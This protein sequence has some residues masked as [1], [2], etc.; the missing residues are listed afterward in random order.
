[1]LWVGPVLVTALHPPAAGDGSPAWRGNDGSLVLRLDWGPTSVVLTGDAGMR[2]ERDL[3][4]HRLPLAATLLKVGHHGSRHGTSSPFVA[5]VAPR[6]ALVS[7]GSRN[8]FGHPHP[9]VLARLDD[10]GAAIYRTDADG[11][12]EVISDGVR[13]VVRRWARPELTEEWLLEAAR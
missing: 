11:A 4:A 13:L 7:A 12:V 3:L 10:V 2:T 1:M 9:E 8:P 6:L 5:A